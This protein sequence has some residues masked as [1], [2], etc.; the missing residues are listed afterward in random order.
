MASISNASGFLKRVYTE[1]TEKNV[2]LMAGG[3]AYSAFVSLA[4]LLILLFLMLTLA[5]SGLESRIV[6]LSNQWLPGPIADVVDQIFVG[7][8]GVGSASIV[9][10]VVLIWGAL[11]IFR[12]LDTAFSEIYETV[13]E[14]SF[15]DKLKDGLVV[16]FALG[17]AVL[18]TIG[19]VVAFAAFS[20][21]IPFS[22]YLIPLVLLGGLVIAFLPMYYVFP[23]R[24]LKLRDVLPGA[25]FA[26]VGWAVFQAL[27]QVYLTFSDP[28][29][30]SFAGSIIVVITYLYFS[31][32]I[33]LL[34][35]VINAAAG[36]HSTGRPGGVGRGARPHQTKREQSLNRAELAAYLRA[37]DERLTTPG[38]RGQ[39]DEDHSIPRSEGEIDLVEYYSQD[40]EAGERWT[41]QLS[42]VPA[43]NVPSE[44]TAN[45]QRTRVA[46]DEQ[47]Q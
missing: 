37:L 26:A 30:G 16:L 28:S 47:S 43:T 8:S 5:G 42:W 34:G 40:E 2:S 13:D 44:E 9:G 12:G 15:A 31:S 33:L 7:N 46:A 39:A 20:D 4:P 22:G 23:D 10:L 45:R 29:A 21:M 24:D 35:A 41:V 18:A 6:E 3:I 25:V 27:F 1:F 11:K 32:L 17:I 14:N 36:G 38:K 19:T